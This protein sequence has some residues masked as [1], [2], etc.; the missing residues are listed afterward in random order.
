VTLPPLPPWSEP[1]LDQSGAM[2]KVWR[3]YFEKLA[4]VMADHETR[5]ETLEP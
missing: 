2:T 1:I 5:I 3:T 4:Q